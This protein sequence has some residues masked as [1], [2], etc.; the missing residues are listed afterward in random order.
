MPKPIL[1]L[2]G[3][4][5]DAYADGVF[6]RDVWPKLPMK[7]RKEINDISQKEFNNPSPLPVEESNNSHTNETTAGN[8]EES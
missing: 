5:L 3:D 6:I 4:M 8:N 1:P 7:L 2:T